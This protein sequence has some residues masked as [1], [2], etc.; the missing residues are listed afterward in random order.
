M[1]TYEYVNLQIKSFHFDLMKANKIWNLQTP[2][3]DS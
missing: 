3:T 1:Q 2:E